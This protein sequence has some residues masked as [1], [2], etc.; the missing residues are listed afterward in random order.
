MKFK[1]G[2]RFLVLSFMALGFFGV[3]L[4]QSIFMPTINTSAVNYE[5]DTKVSTNVAAMISLTVS[6]ADATGTLPI[7][8]D[9]ASGSY[10]GTGAVTVEVSTNDMNG[11]ALFVNTD[12]VDNAL[13]QN[14]VTDRI[15]ALTGATAVADFPENYWGYSVDGGNIYYPVLPSTENPGENSDKLATAKSAKTYDRPVVND[16]TEITIGAK[17]NSRTAD[18]IYSNTVVFTAIPNTSIA[19]ATSMGN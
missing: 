6:G 2:K 19:N 1:Q 18:G 4:G 14:G 10:M 3:F 7:E 11:Y 13:T 12:K 5:D 15:R 16:E 9:M 17:V 8:V